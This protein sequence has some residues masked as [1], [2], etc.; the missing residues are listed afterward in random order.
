[1]DR[2]ATHTLSER[3]QFIFEAAEKLTEYELGNT[4][5]RKAH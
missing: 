1:M 3:V 5:G 2:K 4:I